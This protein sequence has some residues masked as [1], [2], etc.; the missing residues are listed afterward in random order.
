MLLTG[1]NIAHYLIDRGFLGYETLVK[2]DFSVNM[3]S[4]RNTGYIV[5][6]EGNTSYFVK[7]VQMFEGEKIE[8]LRVEANVYWLANNEPEYVELKKFLPQFFN[9]DPINHILMVEYMAGNIDLQQFYHSNKALPPT[10]AKQTAEILASYHRDIFKN[11][12]E[13]KSMRLFRKTIPSPFLTFGKQLA[14]MKPRN[15][16]EEEMQ[17]LIFKHENFTDLVD[18]V[19]N[20]WEAKSLIHGDIKPNNFLINTDCLDTQNFQLRLIDWEIADMGDPLW[21]VAAVF[22]SYLLMWLYAEPMES[23]TAEQIQAAAE[24]GF[25]L[26]KMQPSI[27][28]FWKTYCQLM[29]FDEDKSEYLLIK[30]TRFCAIKLLH[31]SYE[32]SVYAQ[33]LDPQTIRMLQLSLNMLKSPE[34]AIDSLFDININVH[35]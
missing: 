17:N 11:A 4:S 33:N 25:P 21:D 29:D 20:D 35:V 22:Q 14:F 6:S 31:T 13:G 34:E 16:V 19:K 18:Q 5:K 10:I 24:R 27:R 30:T 23:M 2:D 15:K 9:Y 32:S 28:L 8:T 3:A 7:Q 12:Q 1:F 26:E